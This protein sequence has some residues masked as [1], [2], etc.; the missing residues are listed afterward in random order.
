M[1]GCAILMGSLRKHSYP[2]ISESLCRSL[3]L[4]G[5]FVAAMERTRLLHFRVALPRDLPEYNPL[6]IQYRPTPTRVI[7]QGIAC[8]RK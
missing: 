4:S 3:V 7:L 6:Y 2:V 8:M 5:V 1:G